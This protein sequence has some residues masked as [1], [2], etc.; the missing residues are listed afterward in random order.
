MTTPQEQNQQDQKIYVCKICGWH[1]NNVQELGR[2]TRAY[3]Y[4]TKPVICK[5]CGA[6]LKNKNSLNVH[7]SKYHRDTHEH[8]QVAP[9]PQDEQVDIIKVA[10]VGAVIMLCN[11]AEKE[12]I[13]KF[14]E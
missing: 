9:K 13:K 2:H 1:F 4:L 6:Q 14:L 7:I 3:H 5:Y 8:K 11:D 12:A 10:K